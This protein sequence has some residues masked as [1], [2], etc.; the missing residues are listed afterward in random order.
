MAKRV[1]WYLD[2][3][4]EKIMSLAGFHGELLTELSKNQEVVSS[5]SASGA[6][7]IT[8]Y[9]EAYVDHLARSSPSTYHHI[10]EFDK[11]GDKNSR[12]FKSNI[13]GGDFSYSFINSSSPNRNGQVFT[14]K[15]FIMEEGNSLDIYPKQ[16]E[17]LVYDLNGE[18]IFSKH[19][20]VQ[21]PGGEQVKG[22]FQSAFTSFFNSNLPEKALKE[23]GFYSTILNGI[24]KETA[25]VMSIV[26]SGNVS[27]AKN[28]G[29]LAA[30]KIAR[31]VELI[32][33]RL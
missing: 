10:Y 31:R 23:F 33:D 22:A 17:F 5:I 28:Q 3:M 11:V 27:S 19:S 9:F 26:K 6:K 30:H 32:A 8:R 14:K 12:L 15:A 2:K 21:N 29:K 20:F 24:E 16:A 25:A 13:S 18:T 1:G 4:P 7:I